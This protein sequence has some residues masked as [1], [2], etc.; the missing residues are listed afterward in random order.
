MLYI[1]N[2]L[3][4]NPDGSLANFV[5]WAEIDMAQNDGLGRVISK[6]Q[7]VLSDSFDYGKMTACRHANGR[8]WWILIPRRQIGSFHRLLYDPEGFHLLGIQTFPDF[9]QSRRGLG[10]AVF[11]P[12]GTRY[13]LADLFKSGEPDSSYLFHFDRC[14]GLLSDP[15]ALIHPN[16]TGGIPNFCFS[17]NS[18]YLYKTR[19]KYLYQY[20]TYAPNVAASRQL[21]AVADDYVNIQQGYFMQMQLA[22][23][24]KIYISSRTA[25]PFLHRIDYP[26]RPG[27][28]C[29]VC[30]HCVDSL[31]ATT[32]SI[33]SFPHFRLGPLDGSA[34]DTL[35]LDNLPWARFR[36]EV[37]E[38]PTPL[39]VQFTDLSAYEPTEWH[40]D[41]GDPAAFWGNT[42]E[43][44]T[45]VHYFS[46]PGLYN[47][48][49]RVSNDYGADTLCRKVFV[50]GVSEV[51]VVEEGNVGYRVFP[52]PATDVVTIQTI[53]KSHNTTQKVLLFDLL[54]RT[55]TQNTEQAS[56]VNVPLQ[57]LPAGM[58]W[59]V[60]FANDMPVYRQAVVK[61]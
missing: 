47:V 8:D 25:V 40:W 17:P 4:G 23:D 12:D 21:V 9:V 16:D 11:S 43:E 51:E 42:S 27:A 15:E 7:L 39:S 32:F 57:A 24:G 36:F 45:P 50:S 55:V 1:A 18:R 3:T 59:V 38:G 44:T 10:N 41:F 35:G 30:Q 13:A 26:D 20:D 33:P 6:N 14:T 56:T 54:G 19:T 61:N 28:A 34:C 53:T 31:V 22:P 48:C 52:N 2:D 49:L 29:Q 46:A 37:D 5:Y 60:V 58:Y